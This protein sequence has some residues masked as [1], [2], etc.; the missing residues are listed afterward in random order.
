MLDTRR[1]F[2]GDW[3]METQAGYEKLDANKV[4][5]LLP[6]QPRE[7]RKFGYELTTRLGTNATR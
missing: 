6:L 4:K 7:K 5:F 3:T 2:V 1:N